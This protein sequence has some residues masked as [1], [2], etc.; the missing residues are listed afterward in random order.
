VESLR[1]LGAQDVEGSLLKK[2][3]G[4][5]VAVLDASPCRIDQWFARAN[6]VGAALVKRFASHKH[7]R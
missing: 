4:F 2:R 1:V 7:E 3:S 6:S 5:P